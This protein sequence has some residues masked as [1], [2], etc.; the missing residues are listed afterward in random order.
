MIPDDR[1]R[2]RLH[3][4]I[5]A[6]LFGFQPR[7]TVRQAYADYYRDHPKSG[8]QRAITSNTTPGRVDRQS[9]P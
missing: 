1:Q 9:V 3:S 4:I 5:L 2:S 6:D 7:A 8:K